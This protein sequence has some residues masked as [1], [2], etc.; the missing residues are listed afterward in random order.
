MQQGEFVDVFA[1]PVG[2]GHD[3]RKDH[4]GGTDDGG[5]DEHG[6]GGRLEG[7]AGAIVGLQ[8]ILGAIE[9]DVEA[10]VP[11]DFGL[12]VGDLLDQRKLIHRLGIVGDRAVGINRD[13]D[14]AHTEEPKSHQPESEHRGSDHQA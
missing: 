11:L 9:V 6:F 3:D 14:R 7:V 2:E 8:Q 4:R 10:E 1:Q 12:D 5:T 13:G